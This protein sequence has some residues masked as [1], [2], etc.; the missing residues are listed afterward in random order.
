[1]KTY[2]EEAVVKWLAGHLPIYANILTGMRRWI[3]DP[4]THAVLSGY[5]EI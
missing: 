3:Q 2:S 4:A 5:A 1:M